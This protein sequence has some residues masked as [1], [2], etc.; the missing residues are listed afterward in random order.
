MDLRAEAGAPKAPLPN[1]LTGDSFQVVQ[2]N[3]EGLRSVERE[4][5]LG[6]PIF[7]FPHTHG[8]VSP[9]GFAKNE[10]VRARLRE[11]TWAPQAR[12]MVAGGILTPHHTAFIR[13]KPPLQQ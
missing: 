7:D 11:V 12:A 13:N 5:D 9:P 3:P 10:S 6:H 1:I 8:L 2:M 4:P